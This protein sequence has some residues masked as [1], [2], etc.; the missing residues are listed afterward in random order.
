MK[1]E[2][3]FDLK[4]SYKRVHVVH[5]EY[6]IILHFTIENLHIL[7]LPYQF[8]YFFICW[9]G[10]SV[11]FGLLFAGFEVE[12]CCSLVLCSCARVCCLLVLGSCAR[13]CCLML[14]GF[15]AGVFA[16]FSSSSSYKMKWI[17]LVLKNIFCITK[18][19][20]MCLKLQKCVCVCVCVWKYVEVKSPL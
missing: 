13:V 6:C 18:F 7:Y 9:F 15:S 19:V 16:S 12:P 10:T 11:R 5:W 2:Q 14:L 3:Y 1:Y 8:Y 17:I 20:N 4:C